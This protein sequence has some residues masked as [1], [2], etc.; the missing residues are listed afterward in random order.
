MTS[1]FEKK[2][3]AFRSSGRFV[4]RQTFTLY[5]IENNHTR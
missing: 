2:Q 5:E 3:S 4:I 1:V